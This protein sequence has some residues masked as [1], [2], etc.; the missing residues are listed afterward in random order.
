MRANAVHLVEHAIGLAV[1][2]ALDAQCGKLVRNH[3]QVPAGSITAIFA[4]AVS[5]YFRRRLAFVAGTERAEAR[6]LDVGALTREVAGT[7]GAVG[8]DNDQASGY[9]IFAKLRHGIYLK[10][11]RRHS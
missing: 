7:L 11:C 1:N 10:L 3:T 6:S 4:W 5:E 9:R 2:V 8:R